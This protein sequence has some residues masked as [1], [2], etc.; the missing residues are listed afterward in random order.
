MLRS[1]VN[2]KHLALAC[3]LALALVGGLVIGLRQAPSVQA[4]SLSTTF[5]VT[6]TNNAGVGSLRRAILDAN[7][8]PGAD[9]IDFNLSGCPCV[10]SL[11][12][13][14]PT[15]TDTVTIVGPGTGQ[16]AVDGN[17]S[18]RVF[19]IGAVRVTI[20]DLTV[21]HGQHRWSRRRASEHWPTDSHQCRRSCQ[22]VVR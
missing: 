10:I 21:Q 6:S 15:I 16:L 1:T 14:L 19:D 18:V 9:T 13:G 11:T 22:Y 3:G 4:R 7:A 20:S 2:F 8:N 5:T 12:T 17:D